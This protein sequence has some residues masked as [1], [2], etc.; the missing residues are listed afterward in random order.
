MFGISECARAHQF[1]KILQ[2]HA[3]ASDSEH[4]LHTLGNIMITGDN[5][6]S[7][8][9]INQLIPSA[10]HMGDSIAYAETHPISNVYLQELID[11]LAAN[12]DD[13]TAQLYAQPGAFN[14]RLGIRF[15]PSV[16]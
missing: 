3:A 13:P 16:S 15:S 9:A 7:P 2:M 1:F 5:T 12:P 10:G 11:K 6:G 4:L 8:P 14:A